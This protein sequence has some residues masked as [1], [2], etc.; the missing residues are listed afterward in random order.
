M[1]M[2]PMHIVKLPPS[3][4]GLGGSNR[5]TS[6]MPGRYGGDSRKASGRAGTRSRFDRPYV[7]R[8]QPSQGDRLQPE[9]RG[10]RDQVAVVAVDFLQPGLR[11]AGQVEGVGSPESDLIGQP[12]HPAGLGFCQFR[13]NRKRGCNGVGST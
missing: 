6:D 9:V 12:R 3:A 5:V 11:G 8:G 1:V 2:T 7:D 10:S 13:S 4:W